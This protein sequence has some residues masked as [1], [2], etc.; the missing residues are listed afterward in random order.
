[1]ENDR[2]R[3]RGAFAPVPTP[4]HSNLV[5]DAEAQRAHFEWVAS[6]GLDGVL[7]LGTNGEFPSYTFGERREVAEAAAATATNLQLILGV[8]SCALGEVIEMT[9]VAEGCGYG[10]VLCPPPFY[11]RSAP[12]AGL[13]AFFSEV[14]EQ[15]PLPVVLY[16]IPKVTGVPISD[17]LLDLVDGHENLAGVKDSSGDPEELRRLMRRF[18]GRSYLVGSDRLVAACLE[19]GGAGSITAAASVEPALVRAVERG[20][21]EQARLDELRTLL[22]EYGL[23]PSVKALLRRCGLGEFATRPPL[24]GLDDER[25]DALWV[26]F[27]ELVPEEH[28][29]RTFE[30]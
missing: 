6:E 8:G 30:G 23:G 15:S 29:P 12:V 20:G 24:L 13:A 17:G 25:S 18:A 4:V 22:E 28:R 10:S 27:C 19:A 3:P 14:L 9:R 21:G 2:N 5:F 26:R 1:M 16:H 11:F 7:V